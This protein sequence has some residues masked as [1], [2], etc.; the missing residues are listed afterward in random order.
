MNRPRIVIAEDDPIIA[1]DLET[2]LA[3]LGYDIVG[4]AA[5]GPDAIEVVGRT[6]PDLV[7]MDIQLGGA[8][9]GIAAAHEIR[10]RFQIPVVFLSAHAS[11]E[12]V[13]R[14]RQARPLG[15]LT[16]PFRVDEL[17]ATLVMA[18]HQQYVAR[19]LFGWLT[20]LLDSL[21]DAV[22]ATDARGVVRLLNPRAA[23]LTG[24]TPDHAIGR[25]IEDVRVLTSLAGEPIVEGPIRIVLR[26]EAPTGKRRLLLHAPGGRDVAIEESAAPIRSGGRTLGAVTIF[27]DIGQILLEER[28]EATLRTSLEEQVQT[29]SEALGRSRA[30]L[31]ALAAHLLTTQE[32]ER[33]RVARELHDDLG[34]RAA[35]LDLKLER[36]ALL[37]HETTDAHAGLVALRADVRA[38]GGALR[39]VSHRL[40]PAVIEDLGLLAALRALV[41]EHR[42][43]GADVTLSIRDVPEPLRLDLATALYRIAQEALHNARRHAADA[44]VRVSLAGTDGELRLLVEDAGPGFDLERVRGRGSLGLLSM[45]ERARLVGG[46]LLLRTTPG[47]GTCVAVRVPLRGDA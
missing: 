14:A 17:N 15:Y 24:W 3:A 36:A 22:I 29:T 21:G 23:E 25:P 16:K 44:P 18:L 43:R 8:T 2:E 11:G 42:G 35:L 37:L 20:S 7:L 47:D 13:E 26:T 32:D 6:A 12:V 19:E 45:Q 33:R 4:A 31:R 1:M 46:S 9:N 41:D 40:H 39:D 34:Q 30:E 5:T 28:E 27:R 10:D 38:L